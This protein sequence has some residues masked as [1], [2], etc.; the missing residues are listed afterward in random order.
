MFRHPKVRSIALLFILM[1]IGFSLYFQFVIVHMH[2]SFRY[3]NWQLGLFQT[4][5]GLGFALGILIG[6]PFAAKRFHI[7]T[8][9]VVTCLLTGA[10]QV[11]AALIPFEYLQRLIAVF[12]AT[13][14]IMAFSSFLTLFSN[15]VDKSLQG[16][17]MGISGSAMAVAWVISGFSS[18]LLT[19][20]P[21]DYLILIGG[22]CLIL[23][24]FF[25]YCKIIVP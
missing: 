8:I 18:N 6:M 1:Q 2:Y 4:M 7:E 20:F 25:L 11:L 14:D 3:S 23:S 21:S 5:L 9:A 13:A 15:A 12:I 17:V 10:G 16:W 19:L 24:G 22:I